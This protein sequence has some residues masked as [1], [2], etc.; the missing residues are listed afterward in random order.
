MRERHHGR[1]EDLHLLELAIDGRWAEPAEQPEQY[2][3]DAE[4]RRNRHERRQD[5]RQHDLAD[6]PE[7]QP[8]GADGNE[9]R[10]DDAADERVRRTR[11]ESQPPRQDVPEHRADERRDDDVF[12][13]MLRAFH[14]VRADR[15]RDARAVHRAREIEERR[16]DDGVAR[17]QRARRDRRR[18]R[19]RRIV[20]SVDEVKEQRQPDDRE[21]HDLEL[22]HTS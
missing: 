19:V 12:V 2:F 16:H 10:A 11:R 4:A 9:H 20:E 7:I 17:M 5:Q 13:H 15:L 22:R 21:D 1:R 6:A 14:D 8:V 18:D 3:H